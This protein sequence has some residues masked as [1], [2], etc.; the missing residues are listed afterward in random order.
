MSRRSLTG[1]GA[2]AYV[3]EAHGQRRPVVVTACAVEVVRQLDATRTRLARVEAERDRLRAEMH[4]RDVE[5]AYALAR[6]VQAAARASCACV[7]P[8]RI[9]ERTTP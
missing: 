7:T 4:T 9:P 5:H 1:P 3:R 6:V 8:T 2:E